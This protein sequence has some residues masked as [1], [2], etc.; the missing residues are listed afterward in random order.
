MEFSFLTNSF[1]PFIQKDYKILTFPHQNAPMYRLFPTL[2]ER[3]NK[4]NGEFTISGPYCYGEDPKRGWSFDFNFNSSNDNEVMTLVHGCVEGALYRVP[5]WL[6][7]YWPYLLYLAS[8]QVFHACL[9][10]QRLPWE[11]RVLDWFMSRVKQTRL[12]PK[13]S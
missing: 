2:Q 6:M 5:G 12:E 1:L 3:L 8:I 11:E 9:H 13:R 10:Q 7:Y 4:R